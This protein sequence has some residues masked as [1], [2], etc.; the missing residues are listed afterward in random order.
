MDQTFEGSPKAEIRLQGRKVTRSE[1]T[2]DWGSRLQWKIRR[3]GKDLAVVPARAETSYEHADKTPG[4]YE[5]VLEMW[6][7]EGYRVKEHGNFVAISNKV[8][9]TI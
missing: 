7:Y 1:V 3:D 8:T 4:L 6:K 2:N 5:I 9:Y